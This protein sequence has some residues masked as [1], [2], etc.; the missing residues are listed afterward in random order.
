[1]LYYVLPPAWKNNLSNEVDLKCAPKCDR[2]LW[3]PMRFPTPPPHVNVDVCARAVLGPSPSPPPNPTTPKPEGVY[4]LDLSGSASP[5]TPAPPIS[6][7][8]AMGSLA[9]LGPRPRLPGHQRSQTQL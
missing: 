8:M 7:L 3:G 5:H 1:M 9:V 2:W 6:K 4:F